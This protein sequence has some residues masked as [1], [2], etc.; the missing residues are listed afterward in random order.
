MCLKSCSHASTM[1]DRN[2]R[3]VRSNARL[4]AGIGAT[5]V[6]Q[7]GWLPSKSENGKVRY[8][9]EFQMSPRSALPTSAQAKFLTMLIAVAATCVALPGVAGAADSV[10]WSNYLGEKVSRANLD[11]SGDGV[12]LPISGA[13]LKFPTGV[14]IDAAAGRIYVADRG[15]DTILSANLDGSG[16]RELFTGAATVSEPYGLAIDPIAGRLYWANTEIDAISYANLNGSG[17]G[18][19]DTGTAT[20]NNPRGL[21]IDPAAN[22]I[23]WASYTGNTISYAN[24]DGSGGAGDLDTTGATVMRPIGLAID[25]A[26]GRVFWTN[27]EVPEG[28]F[29]A[30][31]GGGNGGELGTTGAALETP[32]GLALDPNAGD[33]F[34]IN[35]LPDTI[36]RANLDGSGDGAELSLGGATSES[37]LYLAL[38]RA[39]N[40]TG[41]PA[42]TGAKLIE[43]PLFCSEGEWAPDLLGSFLYRAPQTVSYA[44]LRNG[45]VIP[46]AEKSTYRPIKPGTYDCRVTA[47]NAAGSSAQTST[48][49]TLVRGFALANGFA[50]V[51]GRKA[52]VTLH[53][54]G[55]GRCRGLVKLI[56]HVGFS[57]VVH[58]EGRREVIRRRALFPIGK[59]RFSI[60]PDRT[61]VVRVKLKRKGKR[62]VDRRRRLRV[63]LL[64]RTVQHRR[65]LLKAG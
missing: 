19:L 20:L 27:N 23:Y 37:P 40:G 53:C 46:G 54:V 65:L 56:A 31:L 63:Q 1:T 45:E 25:K 62:L 26:A 41:I 33:V 30:D 64:G 17:G 51:R 21:A 38:L 57:R 15:T 55:D 28:V 2:A 5:R 58:R 8:E 4:C 22:R 24:L 34:W 43:R 39:P 48:D 61:K 9:G 12:D 52:L 3:V 16:R 42:I 29:Y 44:W 60:F 18:D 14:V 7:A 11:G 6:P 35:S 32:A 47:T 59:A 49:V 36:S 10:Y 13:S 50:P